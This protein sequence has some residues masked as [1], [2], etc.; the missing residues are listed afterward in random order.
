MHR[1]SMSSSKPSKLSLTRSSPSLSCNCTSC[2]QALERELADSQRLCRYLQGS[3]ASLAAGTGSR[4]ECGVGVQQ[5]ISFGSGSEVEHGESSDD[6]LASANL[7]AVL[8]GQVQELAEQ[9]RLAGSNLPSNVGLSTVTGP[10]RPLTLRPRK[11]KRERKS[12]NL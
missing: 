2:A 9:V 5:H 12:G 6:G 8:Q 11:G 7:I 10:L 3:A 1:T 4:Y